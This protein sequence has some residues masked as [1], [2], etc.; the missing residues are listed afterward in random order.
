MSALNL[1]QIVA[2]L[3]QHTSNALG[4]SF[5]YVSARLEK[6][7]CAHK[8][9]LIIQVTLTFFFLPVS[10]VANASWC[11]LVSASNFF[12]PEDFK[13][14]YSASKCHFVEISEDS[15]CLY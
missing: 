8:E 11:G 12:F 14:L 3:L 1:E 15:C 7:S 9:K 2:V 6:L 4:L 10:C 13:T 5:P